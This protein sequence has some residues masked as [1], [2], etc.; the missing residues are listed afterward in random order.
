MLE[1]TCR[2]E[3]TPTNVSL[4]H[5]GRTVI[6]THKRTLS[7]LLR[8]IAY[9][10]R[11]FVVGSLGVDDHD[12]RMLCTKAKI[13]IVTINCRLAPEHPF[14]TQI[15]DSFDALKRGSIIRPLDLCDLY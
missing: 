5:S 8:S 4:F 14:P 6:H 9:I 13:S 1:Y 11:G 12:N 15:D 2:S 7:V 10:G 3:L